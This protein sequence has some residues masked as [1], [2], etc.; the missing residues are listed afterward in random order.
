VPVILLAAALSVTQVLSILDTFC[1]NAEIEVRHPLTEA[2]VSDQI[3]DPK[4]DRI[5]GVIEGRWRFSFCRGKMEEFADKNE[6]VFVRLTRLDPADMVKWSQEP[7][8][9]TETQALEMARRIF[10]KLGYNEKDFDPPDAK[11]GR[12][13]PSPVDPSKFFLLPF[14]GV[15]YFKRGGSHD[16]V[17]SERV[18]FTISGTTKNVIYFSDTTR[19]QMQSLLERTMAKVV[20]LPPEEQPPIEF[21]EALRIC[22]PMLK[23]IGAQIN[24]PLDQHAKLGIPDEWTKQ[25]LGTSARPVLSVDDR[26]IFAISFGK[27]RTFNDFHERPIHVLEVKNPQRLQEMAQEKCSLDEKQALEIASRIFQNLGFR[28]GDFYPPRVSRHVNRTSDFFGLDPADFYW[29]Q[30]PAKTGTVLNLPDSLWI[31]WAGKRLIDGLL[32]KQQTVIMEISGVT[33]NLIF[34]SHTP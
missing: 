17:V 27:L 7:C 33:S 10:Q 21:K 3:I 31:D 2:M 11:R 14:F 20:P 4:H 23:A 24:G 18:E 30:H 6:K 13:I 16:L 15:R 22:E 29:S 34:Y 1:T 19:S 32:N 5:Q 26:Y 28:K 12:W 8:S 25:L 9:I